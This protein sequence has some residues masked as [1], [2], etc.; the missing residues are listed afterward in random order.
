MSPS[1]IHAGTSWLDSVQVSCSSMSSCI[2][3]EW[4]FQ[5]QT[6][7][8]SDVSCGLFY[9]DL[10]AQPLLGLTKELTNEKDS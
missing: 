4:F 8:T 2:Q 1:P 3:T 6:R 9:Q 5:I 7:N 10:C